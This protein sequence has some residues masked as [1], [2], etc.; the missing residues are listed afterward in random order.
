MI[1]TKSWLNEWIDLHGITTDVLAKTFNA[2]G[3]EVDRVE[4]FEIPRKIVFGKVLECE[5]HPDADKLNICKVD[6]GSSIRQIVCGASNVREG[7]TVAV[8]TIGAQMPAPEG[9]ES[10]IIKPVQLRGVDSEGMICSSSELGLPSFDTGI[11]IIDDSVGTIVL[12]DEVSTNAYFNDD[13]IEIELTANRGDCLSILGIARDL[14]AA[15]G[16]ALKINTNLEQ[17]LDEKKIGIGRVLQLNYTDTLDSNISYRAIDFKNLKLPMLMQLR[18]AHIEEKKESNLETLLFYAT[19]NTGVI[20]RAYSADF[21]KN[22]EDSK[23]KIFFENDTNGYASINENTESKPKNASIVG[24]IQAEESFVK[25]DGVTFLE[26]SY[27]PPHLI[28][29][30]M[31]ETKIKKDELF[32][33]TSRGSEPKLH[34]GMDLA[35]SLLEKYSESELY[36]GSFELSHQYDETVIRITADEINS[37][38]GMNIEKRV[39]TKILKDLGF[40]IEKSQSESFI[41]SVP[42]HRHDIVN[43]QDLVEEIVRMVGIDNI[44]S[45]PFQ[46]VEKNRINDDYEVYKKRRVYRHKA[47][48]NAFYESVHFVFNER[49]QLEKYGFDCVNKELE[50]LNPIVNTL[51]TLR[52][53]LM[54]ALLNAVE[55]NSKMNRKKISLFEIGSVFSTDREESIKMTFVSSDDSENEKL[56]NA[57]RAKKVDF[58]T[59]VQSISNVVGDITLKPAVKYEK[60][61]HPYQSSDILID[62]IVIGTLFKLHP[63]VEKDFDLENTFVCELDFDMLSYHL[64]EAKSFSK[65]Q[66]SFRDLSFIVPK[67]MEYAK[68]KSI[69]DDSKTDEIVRFYPVDS[70]HDEKLGANISLSL[71]FV[72]QSHEKTLEEE[73]LVNA[74]DSVLLGLEKELGL[75]LR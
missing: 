50:L 64:K 71:R 44:Q 56:S 69:I 3:L 28:S 12:G 60:M 11:M 13:L 1:V 47:A 54:M 16:R 24:V 29:K 62:N 57:G 67:D 7:I 2:I 49:L 19:Y 51:D 42:R 23:S 40:D 27:I 55:M 35:L 5:K 68:I 20:L 8:A 46:F 32:Y 6:I 17:D 14:S 66:A 37:F 30:K 15:L 63:N 34:C 48:N 21:F 74:M 73:D 43:R 31:Y 65:Y 36:G 61:A 59:F 26:A 58:D 72:L 39:I 4:S 53:T 33:R 70:Y 41:V 9:K 38:I 25:N 52:P 22:E 10:L 75:T 18:M 45:K